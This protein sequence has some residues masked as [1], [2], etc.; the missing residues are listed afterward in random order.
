MGTTERTPDRQFRGMALPHRHT[1][2]PRLSPI[3]K[4]TVEN[5]GEYPRRPLQ[6][7]AAR[8]PISGKLRPQS[9]LSGRNRDNIP[10]LPRPYALHD[11]GNIPCQ[12]LPGNDLSGNRGRTGNFRQAGNGRDTNSPVTPEAT[13]ERLPAFG[14]S[15]LLVR[16]INVRNSLPEDR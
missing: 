10:R 5:P 7:V 9:T 11:K 2:L 4:D 12:P 16:K 8:N 13:T 1:E 15:P 3:Q 14:T 6:D